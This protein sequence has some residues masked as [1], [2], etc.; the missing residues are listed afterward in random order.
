[1]IVP[2]EVQQKETAEGTFSIGAGGVSALC[3]AYRGVCGAASADCHAARISER[4]CV[5]YRRWRLKLLD[6]PFDLGVDDGRA[7]LLQGFFDLQIGELALLVPGV[8][9]ET[10]AVPSGP[11]HPVLLLGQERSFHFIPQGHERFRPDQMQRP[12]LRTGEFR[13]RPALIFQSYEQ[14]L[15]TA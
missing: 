14:K 3:G 5:A 12:Q 11:D 1:M 8:A 7:L 6:P 9:G 2:L 13:S 10:I 15:V 4:G